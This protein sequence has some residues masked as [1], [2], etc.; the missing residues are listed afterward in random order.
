VSLDL[1]RTVLETEATAI[2]NLVDRIGEEFERAIELVLACEG[3]VV[4][5]GMGKSGIICRKLAATMSSTGTPSLFLHPAEA[6][7]GDLGMVTEKDLVVAISKSGS[8]E[9]I[10]RLLEI[11]RRQGIKLIAM[12]SHPDSPLA[13]AADV[14]L[15]LGVRDEACPLN[16]APT[17]STTAS[18]ALGDALALTV[19]VRKGFKEEDFA[20]FHPGGKLGK[21]FLKVKD[22]MHTG[23]EMPVVGGATAMKDVIYEMSRKG[24]GLAVVLDNLGALLGVITDGDLRRLMERDPDPLDH[25]AEEVMHRGGVCIPADELATAALKKL[26]DKRITSLMVCGDDGQVAGV[27][28]IH[29]LWGVGLF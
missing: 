21:K 18:L 17:A 11:L 13:K 5:S 24:L 28:H 15:D 25:I 23:D 10:L 26:E 22:L 6:I 8:T 9:E 4:W 14:H 7:H 12:S 20:R 29:D 19:A 1:A 27:L 16:L 3:R 2:R